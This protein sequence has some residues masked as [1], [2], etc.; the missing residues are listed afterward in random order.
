[1]RLMYKRH[2]KELGE[3]EDKHKSGELEARYR[4]ATQ[5]ALQMEALVHKWVGY[6]REMGEVRALQQR[7]AAAIESNSA[8]VQALVQD[9]L[10]MKEAADARV[11]KWRKQCRRMEKDM[12]KLVR[13]KTRAL[14]ERNQL[15]EKYLELYQELEAQDEYAQ[16]LEANEERLKTA[17]SARAA[18]EVEAVRDE[19]EERVRVEM[20]EKVREARAEMQEKVR[21]MEEKV[22][23]ARQAEDKVRVEMEEKVRE[24]EVAQ[25]RLRGEMGEELKVAQGGRHDLIEHTSALRSKVVELEAALSSKVAELEV[26]AAKL[27]EGASETATVAKGQLEAMEARARVQEDVIGR[28]TGEVAEM[29]AELRQATEQH[30]QIF[31]GTMLEMEAKQEKCAE[32]EALV[33]KVSGEADNLKASYEALVRKLSAELED[34]AN[35]VEE[36]ERLRAKVE[37][38]ERVGE[39]EREA[40]QEALDELTK[41]LS[42]AHE[43][44]AVAEAKA[45]EAEGRAEAATQAAACAVARLTRVTVGMA[46]DEDNNTDMIDPELRLHW[47]DDE[48][49]RKLRETKTPHELRALLVGIASTVEYLLTSAAARRDKMQEQ[50]AEMER[51]A[52]QWESRVEKASVKVVQA[53]NET[54]TVRKELEQTEKDLL[55]AVER[56]EA[57]QLRLAEE[58]TCA[59]ALRER[60]EVVEEEMARLKALLEDSSRETAELSVYKEE[61]MRMRPERDALQSSL[62]ACMSKLSQA[63]VAEDVFKKKAEKKIETL[64]HN[65]QVSQNDCQ[66]HHSPQPT[67]THTHTHDTCVQKDW[68]ADDCCE[69]AYVSRKTGTWLFTWWLKAGSLGR[70]APSCLLEPGTYL[71][72]CW[73]NTRRAPSCLLHLLAA[74]QNLNSAARTGKTATYLVASCWLSKPVLLDD[75]LLLSCCLSRVYAR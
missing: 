42:A 67:H 19:A 70:R 72:P 5:K 8:A 52:E 57:L 29:Q 43:E 15:H 4:H 16:K 65:L 48:Y 26:A 21:E 32:L 2:K 34:A 54:A 25:E 12:T 60:V 74:S 17:I 63:S 69:H 1:M 53:R 24:G 20:E 38:A 36:A 56:G 7:R 37:E 35:K 13:I 73:L 41:D 40:T 47:C 66:A 68:Q 71:F 22:R 75:H 14:E 39:S 59:H 51:K 18:E 44:L 64:K 30:D 49:E 31:E 9:A 6:A 11:G 45:E 55:E 46:A 23:E 27:Q 58:Q 50:V 62:D 28:L 3:L 10:E 61:V 33:S